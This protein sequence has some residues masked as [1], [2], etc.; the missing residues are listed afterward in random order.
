MKTMYCVYGWEPI[1]PKSAVHPK[2]IYKYKEI[3]IKEIKSNFLWLDK[4]KTKIQ[5]K[6]QWANKVK[7][8]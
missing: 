1:I 3:L 6:M 8:V 4:L 5:I 7:R 2:L